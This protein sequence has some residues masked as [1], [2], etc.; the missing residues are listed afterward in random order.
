MTE[1]VNSSI[2]E[3]KVFNVMLA[4]FARVKTLPYIPQLVY[5]TVFFLCFANEAH[6]YFIITRIIEKIHPQYI[7]ANKMKRD[8]LLSSS[9]K[10]V[11]EMYK[12]CVE[13]VD[14]NELETVAQYL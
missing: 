11:L 9:L 8:N 5:L 10:S 1:K 13:R 4:I 14:R 12:V 7:R 6:T 3:T 2:V